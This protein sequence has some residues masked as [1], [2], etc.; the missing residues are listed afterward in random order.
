MDPYTIAYYLRWNPDGD[1]GEVVL[2]FNNGKEA[3]YKVT[4]LSDMAGWS[5]LVRQKPLFI[6]DDGTLHTFPLD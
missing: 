6:S 4:S 2:K 1:I 5:E 3:T